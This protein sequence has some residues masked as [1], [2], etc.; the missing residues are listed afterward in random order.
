MEINFESGY[1]A[2]FI[3]L[4]VVLAVGIGYVLYFRSADS[5][6]FTYAQKILLTSLRSLTLFLIFLLLLAPLIERTKRIKQ[7]PILAVAFDN[8]QSIKPYLP[9]YNQL[10]QALKNSFPDDYQLDFWLFGAK[11]E[12]TDLFT[13]TERRSD[14]GQLIKT[15]RNNYINKNIGALILVG[16]G[17]YNQGQNPAN[18][19]SSLRFPVY[20]VGIG[21]TTH[22]VDALIRNVRTNKIAFLKNRFPVEIELN[23]LKLKNK[24]AY[25]DIENNQHSVYSSTISIH[26]DD[27]FKLEF[28]NL[29]ASEVGMQHYKVRIRSFDGELN[30]NNNEYEFVIQ[31]LENKQK[32][33]MLSDGPHPDLG[34]IRTSLIE[35]QNYD[36]K[37]VTGDSFPDSL[38]VY[39][40]IVLNQ[41]PSVKNVASRLLSRIKDSRIPVLF[42][43]GPGSMLDQFNS[44]EMGLKIVPGRNTEEVQPVFDNNFSLFTLSD[45]AKEIISASPP[46][47]A[48]FGNTNFSASVQNLA[49]QNIRNIPTNKTMLALGVDKGRKVGFVIGEGL[50]RWRLND[51]KMSGNHEAFDEL[52]QKVVQYLALK[53]NEDN[54]NIYSPALFQETDNVEL[55]AELRNDSYQLVNTPDVS[56]KIRNSNQQE[57]SYTFDR[58]DDY[59]TLNAGSL[60]PG[61]YS[62]EAETQLGNQHFS[63]KG[64]FSIVKNEIEVQNGQANFGALYQ[65]SQQTGGQFATLEN[66][67]ILLDTIK[68]NSQIT[69][70]KYKQTVQTEWINLKL[71]F[72]LLLL[73]LGC[74]WFCRKYWGIY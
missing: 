5:K 18:L 16:D 26:S 39:S 60:E 17:I 11:V 4:S 23:F 44:L 34:A 58:R 51:F 68:N 35:L 2:L 70:Q 14:Y 30:L 1:S 57:F 62:F 20:S 71:L 47:V 41:L 65:L 8:S 27:D 74:E 28:V 48:P 9:S 46:L 73:L 63:E 69:I 3:A 12:N 54:F 53:E 49:L 33:L 64:N 67:G 6:S 50:W 37:I 38:S 19:A 61:D 24:I 25:I 45:E 55:T 29:E 15:L 22:K 32:I 52:V 72:F 40:L 13:G 7:L 43:V 21:D 36:I 10:T 56:I 31:V 59:Y 66:Y 42:L